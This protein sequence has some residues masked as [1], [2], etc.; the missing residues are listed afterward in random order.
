MSDGDTEED[1]ADP[2]TAAMAELRKRRAITKGKKRA[3]S[4][5][6]RKHKVRSASLVDDSEVEGW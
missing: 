4:V 6:S 1:P 2:K 5:G 3:H